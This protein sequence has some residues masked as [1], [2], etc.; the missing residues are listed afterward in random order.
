MMLRQPI[1][2]GNWKMNGSITENQQLIE[3]IDA[4]LADV[5]NTQVLIFPPFVYLAQ[6]VQLLK[7]SNSAM[8]F[9]SQNISDQDAGA[10]TGE[11]SSSMLT[12][13]GCDYVLVGHSERRSLYNESN[14][15][16]ASKFV[17]ALEAD[18]VPILCI[19]ESLA[20]RE[21]GQ[22]MDI[23]FSQLDA[24]IDIAGIEGLGKG[25]IAYEPIWAIGTGMTAS[26]EQAQDVHHEIRS[27]IKEL[28]EELAAGIQI[29]YGGS[30][31]ATNAAELFAKQDIDGGLI[32]GASLKA[33]DFIN[34]CVAAG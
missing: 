31:N 21:A 18:L 22:T 9:G 24:V 12:D 11:I 28:D 2:A 33:D 27:H 34:I 7:D 8:K 32:G 14:Q 1:V 10:F 23:V 3:A 25:I 16:V 13:I 29:L 15:F 30:V 17:K 19:G 26:P 4:K 6:T 20:E 5:K